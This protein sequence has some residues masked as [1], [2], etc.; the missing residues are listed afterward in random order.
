MRFRCGPDERLRAGGAK[1]AFELFA[2]SIPKVNGNE[3]ADGIGKR[4][5]HVKCGQFTAHF[6]VVFDKDG[7]AFAG[8]VDVGDEGV[9]LIQIVRDHRLMECH[10]WHAGL[11]EGGKILASGEFAQSSDQAGAGER[12]ISVADADRTIKR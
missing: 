12:G 5:V 1:V 2:R 6:Q 10:E 7:S 3:P 11:G 8:T 4:R 9:E